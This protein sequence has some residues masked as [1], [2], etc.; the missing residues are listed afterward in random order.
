M[1]GADDGQ[2]GAPGEQSPGE[3]ASRAVRVYEL[4]ALVPYQL[5]HLAE[6]GKEAAGV[7]ARV[8][9]QGPRLLGE[10]AV[11]EADERDLGGFTQCMQQ[12]MDVGLCPARVAAA[13]QM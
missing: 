13:Y 12:G 4:E 9:A 8:Y 2:A 5:L 1:Y 10:G 6:G 11:T 7:D 3:V